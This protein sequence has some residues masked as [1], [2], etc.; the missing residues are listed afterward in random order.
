MNLKYLLG[1]ILAFPLLPI[2]Y[3]QGKKVRADIPRLPEAKGP[4]GK[5]NLS[6][7]NTL[8][9]ITIGESTIA[10]VGVS[11]HE[12]GFTGTLATELASVLNVDFVWRVYAES[13]FTARKVR[14][15]II[16]EI[17]EAEVDLIAIG[18][19]GNDAFQLTSPEQWRKDILELI[20]SLR[21][22]FRETPIIFTNM[23]PIRSFPAF[24]AL[25]QITLGNLV[26]ILGEE[27]EMLVNKQEN[28]YYYAR[29]ITLDDWINRLNIKADPTEFFCDGIH[30][31][32][33]TYQ[34]WAKDFA[35]FLM[36]QETIKSRLL[37][38][39]S[40]TVK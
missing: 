31:S 4:E 15:Q 21:L 13:G 3:L 9:L 30:P 2:M 12:E 8:R 33:L 32:K 22:K 28:V 10:G 23:P 1:S 39:F 26:E 7:S 40:K 19:G 6:T 36:Q 17:Q 37:N 14:E 24:P 38:A 27:L 5:T 11:S 35:G 34:V 16:P 20:R 29:K 25:M 18:L